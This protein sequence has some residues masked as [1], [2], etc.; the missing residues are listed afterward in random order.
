M[1]YQDYQKDLI[2]YKNKKY[3]ELSSYRKVK[4]NKVDS[5]LLAMRSDLYGFSYLTLDPKSFN[6]LRHMTN[7]KL[8]YRFL[9]GAL[10]DD[11]DYEDLDDIWVKNIYY[12]DDPRELLAK[13]Y[14]ISLVEICLNDNFWVFDCFYSYIFENFKV[15][16]TYKTKNN[17][18]RLKFNDIRKFYKFLFGDTFLFTHVINK[19]TLISFKDKKYKKTNIEDFNKKKG[20]KIIKDIIND[21]SLKRHLI[22]L[23]NSQHV[24][25]NPKFLLKYKTLDIESLLYIT[26][27]EGH[28]ALEVLDS[29]VQ[30]NISYK[31]SNYNIE[32][33]YSIGC[34]PAVIQNL[35][36]SDT[37]TISYHTKNTITKVNENKPKKKKE[38][39]FNYIF[40]K[41]F[42]GLK[43][44]SV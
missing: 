15:S 28:D 34:S 23:N 26:Y 24:D 4:S 44:G 27:I 36:S 1:K 42:P 9:D 3:K 10:V 13:L 30:N 29:Y 43:Y 17:I 39:K 31:Y 20:N 38:K 40:K 41:Y 19:N 5:I 16:F 32:Y 37:S 22:S 2:L 14:E 33:L 21:D 35:E 8:S 25:I 7:I 6:K 18:K 12:Y 11:S